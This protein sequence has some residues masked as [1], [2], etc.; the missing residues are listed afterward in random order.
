MDMDIYKKW[1]IS[2]TRMCEMPQHRAARRPRA[3]LDASLGRRMALTSTVY[4]FELAL[5]D[6]DR[7][8]YE[9][10][11][12]KVACH[13]SETTESMLTRVLAYALE[14]E[15]GIAFGPGVS[16]SEEP[17]LTVRDLTGRLRAWIEV[18]TPDP[19]RLHKAS[20]ACDRVVV[21]CHKD[22]VP[23][24]RALGAQKVHAPERV[25]LVVLDRRFIEA[26]A[27][28]V[29]RRT[30][31]SVSVSGGQLYLDIGGTS[32]SIELR[33]QGLDTLTEAR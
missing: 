31:L 20:K 16:T 21:Y 7:G 26:A 11:A 30:T 25:V 19:A 15:E 6:V 33:R 17:A 13:P 4:T 24:L 29:E 9:T 2:P 32:S 12:L 27:A 10:L 28:H 23:Y 8:V 1:A 5:S 22:P 18:G 3:G 14:F